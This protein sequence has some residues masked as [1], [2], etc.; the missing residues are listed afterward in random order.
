MQNGYIERFNRTYR[1]NVLDS[2]IFE[3]LE[4]VREINDEYVKDYNEERPHE[5]LAGLSPV[6]YREKE[7]QT[8]AVIN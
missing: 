6:K 8:L 1:E 3:S 4:D 2:Y 7:K 5:S